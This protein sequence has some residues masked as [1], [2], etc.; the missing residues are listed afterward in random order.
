MSGAA[1]AAG[2]LIA[3]QSERKH[4]EIV[5]YFETQEALDPSKAVPMPADTG[6]SKTVL[7]EML[8]HGELIDTGGGK[9]WLDRDRAARRQART[10]QQTNRTLTIVSAVAAAA[11]I[12]V[13]ALR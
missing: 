5:G 11:A 7:A 10:K 1:G 8:R 4:R 3:A 6:L 9:F 12:A 13:L 2:A